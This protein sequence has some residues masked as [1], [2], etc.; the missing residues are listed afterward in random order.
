MVSPDSIS[1]SLNYVRPAAHERPYPRSAITEFD[2]NLFANTMCI[3]PI[4]MGGG[5]GGGG[6]YARR[7]YSG[8]IKA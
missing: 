5:G 1:R 4:P 3:N 7:I 8:E 2:A 6:V